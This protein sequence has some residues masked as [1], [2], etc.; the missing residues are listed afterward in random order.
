MC[1]L[2]GFFGGLPLGEDAL[3]RMADT[4][5]HR[6]PDATGH[7][8]DKNSRLGLVHRRLSILDL[9]STGNQP[10]ISACHRFVLVFNGEIYNHF[11]LRKKLEEEVGS[12]N[13]IGRSDTETL[14]VGLRHWGIESCLQKLNGMF[15]FAL[16]DRNE[17]KLFLARDRMGEKPLYFG[18]SGSSFLFGSEIKALAAHPEWQGKID[19]EALALFMRYSYIPSPNSIYLGIKKLQPA[20]YIVVKNRGEEVSSPICYWPLCEVT[21]SGFSQSLS[22]DVSVEELADELDSLLFDA[23]KLRMLA[24]VPL[25]AFLS[26][27][28]DS[29]M[30][31]SQMQRQSSRAVKTFTIGSEDSEFDE[32]K[33]AAAVAKH[34]GT[35]HSELFVTAQEALTVIPNLPKTFD[36]PFADSSQI[37]T[38]LVSQMARTD[39]TVALSGDGGDELFG[40]YNRHIFGPNIWRGLSLMPQGIRIFLSNRF[41]RL[42]GERRGDCQKYL[43][44]RLK[45][46]AL[47]LKAD[48][49]MAALKAD[50][51][52]NFY[53]QLLARWREQ[54]PVLGVPATLQQLQPQNLGLLE[55]MV[56]WDMQTYLPDDILTK[57]DRASM[58]V[59]L[60]ARA[61]FLDHR[62]IEFSSRVPS[63]FKVRNGKG[64]W[65]L[66]EVLHRHVPR[67]LMERPKQGFSIPISKW[68]R[69][70]LRDWAE[71]LIEESRIN[72]EGYLDAKLVRSVWNNHLAGQ[73]NREH[74][75]WCVLMFQSWLETR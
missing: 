53:D 73:G 21:A 58:A 43:F 22:D 24:D 47:N 32:A 33:N 63:K 55:Q 69:G 40:G 29:T 56:Y 46:P 25:G 10:M 17:Q 4:L 61:P 13:W 48:K 52:L 12:L 6:G 18:R 70:P 67:S 37:P 65:L 1:G 64:K 71:A 54:G 66:R 68:L 20:H 35:D 16:W 51:Y 14:L 31:V 3:Y 9:T 15:A 11:D 36:E 50:D 34:L 26:G 59:S 60:E 7:W 41:T 42:I 45:Y 23:V 72:Q 8:L 38:F 28:Y 57:V 30:V 74:D 44:H 39:V 62:L 75:L 27:G 2:A 5:K 49:V 19:R